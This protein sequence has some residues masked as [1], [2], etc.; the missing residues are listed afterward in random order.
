MEY[1]LPNNKAYISLQYKIYYVKHANFNRPNF[2]I[3]HHKEYTKIYVNKSL[4]TNI[5]ELIRFSAQKL[6][7]FLFNLLK[8]FEFYTWTAL[9]NLKII[10]LQSKIQSECF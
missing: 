5:F 6:L 1:L 3:S 4:E 9:Q 10:V 8:F 2:K 7:K